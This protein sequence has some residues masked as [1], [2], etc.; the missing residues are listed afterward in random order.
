LVLV[1]L[2]WSIGPVWGAEP[3]KIYTIKRYGNTDIVCDSYTVQKGDHIWKLLRRKGA[4]A[5]DDFPRFV[6]ILKRFNPHIRNVNRIYP[7][8]EILIPLKQTEVKERRPDAGP[9]YL[10]IPII[11]DVL[12]ITCKVRPG[13]CLSK[14][15]TARLGLQWDQ[16]PEDYVQTLKRLNPTIKNMDL[17]H[18]GQAIRIPEVPA[19]SPTRTA[20]TPAAVPGDLVRERT[21]SS[22]TKDLPLGGLPWWQQV[23]SKTIAGLGG[24]LLA[25]GQCYFPGKDQEDLALDLTAFPVIEMEDGRHLI[26]KWRKGFPENL[27]EAMR[28]FWDPL[29]IM[30]IDPGE[31]GATALDK[32]FRAISGGKVQKILDFPEL[33]DG[34]RVSLRG[35]WILSQDDNE[36]VLPAYH[37]ITLIESPEERTSAPVVEYLA[38][39]NIRVL[40]I[41]AEGG[42]ENKGGSGGILRED[43]TKK[44]P[45]LTIDA[46]DQ[47][48]FV[49][50]FVTAMGYSYEPRVPFSF[51]YAGFQVETTTNI[52]HG[53]NT[54]DVVVDFGTFY[55]DAK[56]AIEAGGLEVVSISPEDEALTIVRNI[57]R[58]IGIP[59]TE[60][61]VFFGANRNVFRPFQDS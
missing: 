14:I 55:G 37:C 41:L 4:I 45:M 44:Y 38:R 17:I 12:Y 61:P 32:V 10:T 3:Y 13:E 23:V 28:S 51:D 15:V 5:E 27:E 36:G 1:L 33:D 58:A 22:A 9:R 24:K 6:S 39:E 2:L 50:G 19:K 11:P 35:D 48:A 26:L 56:S 18:P 30:G 20:A 46:S 53:E 29:V 25:S 21:V 59:F 7:G 16:L 31:P 54:L 40:D 49:S 43:L 34:I 8:Q 60:N 42:K 47:E 52:I 57:L